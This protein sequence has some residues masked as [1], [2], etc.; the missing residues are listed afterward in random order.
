MEVPLRSTGALMIYS[1]KGAKLG[2]TDVEMLLFT[3][4][5]DGRYSFE[6]EKEFIWVL[7]LDFM[8]ILMKVILRFY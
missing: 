5:V 8:M 1:D 6:N 4:G 7:F 3:L 2:S